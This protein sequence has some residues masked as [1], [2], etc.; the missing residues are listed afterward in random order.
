MVE[1]KEREKAQTDAVTSVKK[2]QLKKQLGV[3]SEAE[4][5]GR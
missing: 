1:D 2:Q 5:V 4:S 3:L